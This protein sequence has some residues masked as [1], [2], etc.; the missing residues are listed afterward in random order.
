MRLE[1]PPPLPFD[2]DVGS[3]EY[4][5]DGI[6][7]DHDFRWYK[8]DKAFYRHMAANLGGPVLELGCGTGRLM[9]DWVKEGLEVTGVDLSSSML[10]RAEHRLVP[11]GKKR[12]A[13][14][15]LRRGNMSTLKL[16][17]KYNVVVSAFNTMMHLYD[18]EALSRFLKNVRRHLAPGG[19]F[20]F[21]VLNPDMRWILRDPNRRWA[22]TRFRHP[23]YGVW[24]YY[25]TNHYYDAQTQIAYVYIYHEPVTEDE[26]PT[27]MMRLAHR[28]FFPCELQNELYHNGFVVDGL[29][30]GFDGADLELDSPSQVYICS[31][32]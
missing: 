29:F 31:V 11:L 23:R 19:T 14:W 3:S 6:I 20:L 27:Y 26:G 18:R 21:D 28:M 13:Q 25:S 17:Q 16:A 4:Y 7:Y 2:L 5:E 32:R 24:Y 22:R 12:R 30:G 9:Y 15:T 8:P 10:E 1:P